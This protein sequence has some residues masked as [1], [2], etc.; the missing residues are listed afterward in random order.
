[1][2]LLRLKGRNDMRA[3]SRRWLEDWKGDLD[4]EIFVPRAVSGGLASCR[5]SRH[6]GRRSAESIHSCVDAEYFNR[7]IDSAFVNKMT[8]SELAI[9]FVSRPF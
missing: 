6:L 5:Q 7:T 2:P 9:D 3:L 4:F 8:L 1:M